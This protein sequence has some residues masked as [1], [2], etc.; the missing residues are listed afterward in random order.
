MKDVIDALIALFTGGVGSLQKKSVTTMNVFKKT[1]DK[2][3]QINEKIEIQV[4]ARKEKIAKLAAEKA[5]LNAQYE[6]NERVVKKIDEFF[7]GAL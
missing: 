2:L 7:E 6:N 5:T 3:N 4:E 1:V